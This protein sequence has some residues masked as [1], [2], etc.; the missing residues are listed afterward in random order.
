MKEQII[1]W[2]SAIIMGHEYIIN[3]HKKTGRTGYFDTSCVSL[4]G[5]ENLGTKYGGIRANI[6]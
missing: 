2:S 5:M 4:L 1:S 6:M 3:N